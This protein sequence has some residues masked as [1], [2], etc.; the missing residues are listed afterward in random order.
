MQ[1]A[2]LGVTVAISD[3]RA[4]LTEDGHVKVKETVFISDVSK[5]GI[6]Y[7]YLEAQDVLVSAAIGEKTIEITQQ[8]QIIDFLLNARVGDTLT[9]VVKRNNSEITVNIPITKNAINQY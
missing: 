4:Y 5:S 1:R 8:H 6:A 3:S 7:G 9:V 2:L